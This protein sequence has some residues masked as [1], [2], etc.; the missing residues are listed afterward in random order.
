MEM[1]QLELGIR[2]LSQLKRIRPNDMGRLESMAMSALQAS[3]GALRKD[4][5]FLIARFDED[6]LAFWLDLA[7]ALEGVA[8]ALSLVEK[9][10]LGR[11]CVVRVAPRDDS[12]CATLCRDLSLK[13]NRTGIWCDSRVASA[14]SEYASFRSSGDFYVL[15]TFTLRNRNIRSYQDFWIRPDLLD[16]LYSLHLSNPSESRATIYVEGPPLMG[17]RQSLRAALNSISSSIEVFRVSFGLNRQGLSSVADSVTEERLRTIGAADPEAEKKLRAAFGAVRTVQAARLSM[18]IPAS[19]REAFEA[20]YCSFVDSWVTAVEKSKIPVFIA[21]NAHQSDEAS[22]ALLR[23][24]FAEQVK[25]DRAHLVLTGTGDDSCC[26]ICIG[27]YKILRVGAPIKN[28]WAPLIVSSR[29]AFALP[30]A[31]E[32]LIERCLEETSANGIPAGYRLAVGWSQDAEGCPTAIHPHMTSDFLEIAYAVSLFNDLF[33]AGELAEAFSAEKKPRGALEL[34]LA[35]LAQLGVVDDENEPTP[36]IPRFIDFA[37]SALGERGELIRALARRRLSLAIESKRLTN[38]YESTVRQVRLGGVA[39][40]SRILDAVVDGVLRGELKAVESAISDGS[41][42]DIVGKAYAE[43]LASIFNTRRALVFGDELETRS[44]FSTPMLDRFPNPRYQAYSFLDRSSYSFTVDV[45][46]PA[47]SAAAAN[48]A[49]DALLLLQGNPLDKGLSRAYRLLGE[50][51][52]SRQRINEAVDYFSFAAESAERAAEPN[53]ALLS[54]VNGACTQFLLG[55]LSKAERHALT[56]ERRALELYQTEWHLWAR[57]MYARIRFELGAYEQSAEVFGSLSGSREASALFRTWRDRAL[58]YC[59]S[60]I[61][62]SFVEDTPDAA[63]FRI[64]SA[65]LRGAYEE[66]IREADAY[67]A[68]PD[69]GRFRNPERVDWSS[70]FALVE[71]RAIGR[72]GGERVARRLVRVFRA[73][74]LAKIERAGEAVAE[75][76]RLAKE[77][78]MSDLDPND[79][80]YFWALSV[81]LKAAGAQ[82]VDTGTMLSIAF[83]RLQRRASRIDDAESKRS[84]LMNNRWNGA[85]YG[86][87]KAIYLI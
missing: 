73:L 68:A 59:D 32:A 9:E 36:A 15:E 1:I 22:R 78:P 66:T 79:A 41:F 31:D 55:N 44:T 47:S 84:Y 87:A 5:G 38:S 37:Q 80:F 57:F 13:E 4:A 77:E 14:L 63:F 49:K 25:R 82:S 2:Y 17:K 24:A 64:E 56:A 69:P 12:D 39:D 3:G 33:P 53:E 43:S 23:S 18:E 26:D 65:F 76:H 42:S 74:A 10:L 58:A 20:F 11:S 21:E 81:S 83:K 6:V 28:E 48:A 46:D 75:L 54:S 40:P 7:I 86:D 50:T 60:A 52:L 51:E 30:A 61:G 35:H 72:I 16:A 8:E 70:G 19:P 71:D 62:I 67:A 34:A 29:Q 85:L 27:R 45:L